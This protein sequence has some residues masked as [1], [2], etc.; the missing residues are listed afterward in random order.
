MRC[1]TRAHNPQEAIWRYLFLLSVLLFA[2]NLVNLAQTL[3]QTPI[4]C[5]AVGNKE[6]GP[7]AFDSTLPKRSRTSPLTTDTKADWTKDAVEDCEVLE[8]PMERYVCEVEAFTVF[9]SPA[10]RPLVTAKDISYT[11]Y[12]AVRDLQGWTMAYNNRS[13]EVSEISYRTSAKLSELSVLLCL[14]IHT[15]DKHCLKPSAYKHLGQGQRISQVKQPSKRER[16]RTKEE[17]ENVKKKK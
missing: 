12:Y 13:F 4:L 14:G 6:I 7:R 2:A 3:V 16:E 11:R 1:C 17:R 9:F 5:S 8:D 15:Q 10:E